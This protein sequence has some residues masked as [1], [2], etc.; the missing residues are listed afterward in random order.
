MSVTYILCHDCKL[1]IKCVKCD[2]HT[3]THTYHRLPFKG[4]LAPMG[5]TNRTGINYF[6][7][8]LCTHVVVYLIVLNIGTGTKHTFIYK[9]AMGN[10]IIQFRKMKLICTYDTVNYEQLG[11]DITL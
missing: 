2:I 1:K 9:Q 11:A 8:G 4:I 3:Y 7:F 10:A 5:D 6:G